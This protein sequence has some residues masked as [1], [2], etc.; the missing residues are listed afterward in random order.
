M[1]LY[2]NPYMAHLRSK[3]IEYAQKS[4]FG[5]NEIEFARGQKNI[6][7]H[8]NKFGLLK[9]KQL[10]EV[11]GDKVIITTRKFNYSESQD[12][13]K[14]QELEIHSATY[15]NK[16]PINESSTTILY[17]ND[18]QAIQ[19]GKSYWIFPN[20]ENPEGKLIPAKICHSPEIDLKQASL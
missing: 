7:L 20:E 16:K 19:S 17:N 8:F 13:A 11:D 6:T 3:G 14:H 2:L 4:V 12:A 5:Y 10:R 1:K 15:E 18:N 9:K